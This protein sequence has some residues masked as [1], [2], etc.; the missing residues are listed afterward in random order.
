MVIRGQKGGQIGGQKEKSVLS[1][2]L[3]EAHPMPLQFAPPATIF[4]ML[5]LK[6]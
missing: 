1:V 6:A 2:L 5:N 4:P 3:R